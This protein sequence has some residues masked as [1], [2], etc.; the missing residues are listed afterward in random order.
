MT[1]DEM[2]DDELME[3][4]R[5]IAAQVDAPPA[6]AVAAARAAF[7]TRELDAEL[8]ALVLDSE[9]AAAGSVRADRADA[10][11]LSFESAGVVLELQVSGGAGPVSIRG[12][13]TGLDGP[14]TLETAGE[15][16]T[17]EVSADGWFVLDGVPSGPARL[18]LVAADGTPVTTAWV[19]L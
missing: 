1:G 12:L 14:V 8:A 15:R 18:H 5:G 17:V 13:G 7:G 6:H 3:R 4:L 19:S 11:L 16:R 9:L 10:R 2:T